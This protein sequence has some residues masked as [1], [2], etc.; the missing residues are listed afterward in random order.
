MEKTLLLVDDDVVFLRLLKRAMAERGFQ[1]REAASIAEGLAAIEEEPPH[2]AVFDLRLPDGNGLSLVSKLAEVNPKAHAI[3]LTGYGTIPSAVAAAK[4]G[5]VDYIA[6]P[7]DA[8]EVAAALQATAQ[9]AGPL[10][11]SIMGPDEARVQHILELFEKNDRNVSRTAEQLEMHRRTLQRILRRAGIEPLE[12]PA[13]DEPN[14]FGRARRL[15]RV[16]GHVFPNSRGRNDGGDP[17]GPGTPKTS[18]A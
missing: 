2:Y 17:H 12:T 18:G 15:F 13:G 5:A 9:K 8:D 7:V 16:W 3:I 10:P 11:R 6:K 1:V 4:R 14:A